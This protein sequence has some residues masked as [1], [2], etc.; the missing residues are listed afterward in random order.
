MSEIWEEILADARLGD[1]TF[2]LESRALSGG[3]TFGRIDPPHQPAQRTADTGRMPLTFKLSIPLFNGVEGRNDL[4]P[5]VYQELLDVFTNDDDKGLVEYIDPVLGAFMVK[6]ATWA[7]DEGADARDGARITCVLEEENRDAYGIVVPPRAPG[8]EAIEAAAE[9]DEELA[10][11]GVN[12]DAIARA[13]TA[14]GHP[15]DTDEVGGW[16]EGRTFESLCADFQEGLELGTLYADR[17]AAQIDR[18]RSRVR[19][20]LQLAELRTPDG[21]P[22]YSAALRLVQALGQQADLAI[23]RATPIVAFEVQGPLSIYDVA[24]K[25]YGDAA[26]AEEIMQRNAI[27]RPWA[28]ARGTV[29][30]VAAR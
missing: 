1:V 29:L 14:S 28:I 23:A 22:A 6:I 8:R 17:V 15:L 25:L 20:L 18:A 19:S 3:R 13:M 16:P 4:Y 26:R 10:A 11:L 12:D 24:V 27:T 30:R 21:F 5:T 2:P 9:L 7:V